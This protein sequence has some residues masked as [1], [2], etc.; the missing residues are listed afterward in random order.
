MLFVTLV[1]MVY[2]PVKR[3]TSV[4]LILAMSVPPL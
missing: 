4:S 3:V 1:D 2:L